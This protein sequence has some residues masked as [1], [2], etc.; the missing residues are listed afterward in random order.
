MNKW[1]MILACGALALPGSGHAAEAD[2]AAPAEHHIYL[3]VVPPKDAEGI[4]V[5]V[6]PSPDLPEL[7][8]GIDEVIILD[9]PPVEE[10]EME[11]IEA[12]EIV[13]DDANVEGMIEE[14][15]VR[16]LDE[17][18]EA[19]L[20]VELPAAV[21][22]VADGAVRS[23]PPMGMLLFIF[24]L[25]IFLGVELISKV[26]SQLHTPLMSGSNAISGI[27]IVGALA[28]AGLEGTGLFSTILGTLAVAFATINVV[29]GYLVTDRMLGMFKKKDGGRP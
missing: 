28:A 7:D 9:E 5:F 3:H 11:I 10:G 24:I 12:E 21:E 25:A 22:R 26:P 14:E 29:G 17:T 18:N 27:T 2:A 6:L 15:V 8:E 4:K 1:M 13:L 20:I 16:P 23:G 19:G